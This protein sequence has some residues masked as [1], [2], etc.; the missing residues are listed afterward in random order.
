VLQRLI[1]SMAADT[2]VRWVASGDFAET[3]RRFGVDR[4]QVKAIEGPN[5]PLQRTRF[6]RR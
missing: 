4:G 1:M 6:A 2:R 3:L 5:C